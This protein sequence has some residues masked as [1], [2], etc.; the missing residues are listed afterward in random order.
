METDMAS[1]AL[2][3]E[4]PKCGA[5]PGVGCIRLTRVPDPRDPHASMIPAKYSHPARTALVPRGTSGWHR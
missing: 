2:N 4:C 1:P 3:Y 5:P